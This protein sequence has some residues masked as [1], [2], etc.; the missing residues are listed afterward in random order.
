MNKKTV[1]TGITTT[2]IPHLGNYVGAIRPALSESRNENVNACYFLADL[3]ALVKNRDP[4]LLRESTLAIAATWLAMGLDPDKSMFYRQSDIPDIPAL[5]WM[6]SSVTSKGLM[7]RSHAYKAFVQEN[8]INHSRDPDKGV[9]MAL[10]TYPILMAADILIFNAHQVPVGKDQIQHVEMAR[11]IAQRF[12]HLYG[13]TFV[14]P[15]AV[16]DNKTAVLTGLDGRKMSKTYNNSIPLFVDSDKLRKLIM[17]IK[18]N[19]L[20]P[21]QPK[22]PNESVIFEIFQAFSSPEEATN[23]KEKLLEGL[24]WGDAKQILFEY[25]DFYLEK[26]RQEYNRLI[27]DSAYIESILKQG[28]LKAQNKSSEMMI[29][30]RKAIGLQAIE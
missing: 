17:K 29:K 7:N 1:L 22:D 15:E 18:T 6:L 20:Q 28:A 21:G 16:F 2:G 24:G 14:I 8:K 11:D 13:E 19:S 26:P 4:N 23:F 5:S 9:T 3:H 25:L 30:V 27:M 12:N 10:F